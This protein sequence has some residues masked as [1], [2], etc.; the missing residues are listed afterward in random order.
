[1]DDI[2]DIEYPLGDTLQ[3]FRVLSVREIV[4]LQ[5][6]LAEERAAETIS[7]GTKAGI[8][9]DACMRSAR[10]ARDDCAMTSTLLRYVVSLAGAHRVFVVSVGETIAAKAMELV[11]PEEIPSL[12]LGVVGYTWRDDSGNWQRRSHKKSLASG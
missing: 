12:A 9:A 8:T 5:K 2:G 4:A 6:R 10:E 3:K 7:D 11:D 1:M